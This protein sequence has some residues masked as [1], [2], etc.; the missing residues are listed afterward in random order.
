[1]MNFT[2]VAGHIKS[3]KFK[4]EYSNWKTINPVIL[5]DQAE[6]ISYVDENN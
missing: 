2:S 5:L 6:I 3:I 1:M 4:E